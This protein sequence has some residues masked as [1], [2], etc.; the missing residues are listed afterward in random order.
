MGRVEQ[1]LEYNKAIVEVG[2]GSAFWQWMQAELRAYQAD[3]QKGLTELAPTHDNL[4]EFARLQERFSLAERLLKKPY[5][6]L[7][8]PTPR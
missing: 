3:A 5:D 2:I 1:T 7:G 8:V 6:L 4:A